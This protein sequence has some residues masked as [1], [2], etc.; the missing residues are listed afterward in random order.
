LSAAIKLDLCLINSGE[1]FNLSSTDSKLFSPER[2]RLPSHARCVLTR[3][4]GNLDFFLNKKK[5]YKWIFLEEGTYIPLLNDPALITNDF[6]AKLKRAT[7]TKGTAKIVSKP[8]RQSS[9]EEPRRRRSLKS[10]AIVATIV[11]KYRHW[12]FYFIYSNIMCQFIWVIYF[13]EDYQ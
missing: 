3:I 4:D 2:R 1:P 7:S 9:N 11:Q 8:G 10:V 12:I 5:I 13:W 6:L